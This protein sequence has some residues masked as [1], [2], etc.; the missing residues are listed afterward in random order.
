MKA[1]LTGLAVALLL[2]II[3]TLPGHAEDS[4]A[5]ATPAAPAASPSTPAATP[6]EPPPAAVPR[7]SILPKTAEPAQQP[8]APQADDNSAPRRHRHYAHRHYRW[9]YAYW[10]PF[11]FYWPHFYHNRIYWSRIHWF[12]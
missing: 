8:I 12:F 2:T 6:A 9:H 11:A 3:S 10:Q 1:H 5:P 4:T 7:P